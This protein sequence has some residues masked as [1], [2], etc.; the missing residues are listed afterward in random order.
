M[1]SRRLRENT[2]LET[3]IG[4]TGEVVVEGHAIGRLDGFTFTQAMS[5]AGSDAKALAGAAQ[6][7]LAGELDSRAYKLAQAPDEQFVLATDGVIRWQGQPVGRLMAGDEV[8][9]PRVR[10]VADEQLAGAPRDAVQARIDLWLKTHIEKLLGPLFQLAN[11]EDVSGLARGVAFQLCEA[12]G[13]IERGKIADDVKSLD[14]PARATLRKYGVR[15]GAYHIYLPAL[16]K[17]APRVLATQLYALKQDGVEVQGLEVAERLAASGRTSIATEKE[18]ARE[19][20]RLAGFRVCGERAVRVDILERLADIIRP[21][22]VWRAGS[23]G[24]KPAAATEGFGFVVTPAMTSLAGCSGDDFASVLRALGYRMEKRPK[25]AQPPPVVEAPAA[26]TPAAE[27]PGAETPVAETPGADTPSAD[28]PGAHTPSA[29]TATAEA[30]AED[31]AAGEMALI[32]AAPTESALA[33]EAASVDPT[34]AD[35]API[36]DVPIETAPEATHA[37]FVS[38]E[39]VPAPV[40]HHVPE[41]LGEAAEPPVEAATP[42]AETIVAESAGQAPD[43]AAQTTVMTEGPEF[44]E[45]WRPGRPEGQRRPRPQRPPREG[46][47]RRDHRRG[48][49][50]TSPVAA[51]SAESAPAASGDTATPAAAD[52]TPTTEQR[53]PWRRR[54]GSSDRGDQRQDRPERSARPQRSP[55]RPQRDDRRPHRGDRNRAERGAPRGDRPDRDPDLRAK[56]IKGRDGRD[57]REAQ[58]DPNSPFAKLAAL[59]AQLEANKEPT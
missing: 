42:P 23:P 25:P 8:L 55:D 28:T 21:A 30:Q 2:P 16:L 6:K 43:Q 38:A 56:Y 32:E 15:F 24:V 36:A 20:Y 49:S 7:A 9:K 19:L 27:T 39:P 50:P 57:R 35:A 26:D 5:A 37:E 18:V 45:V 51:A 41:G 4:K 29:E 22:L 13:V 1:L 14:Q 44:I 52:A 10:I 53:K 58:P 12:L 48:E 34:P 33:A 31:V 3:A 59:K 54:D 46:S 17:P 11:A 40:L 47:R